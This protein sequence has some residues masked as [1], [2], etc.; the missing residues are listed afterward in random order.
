MGWSHGSW[1]KKHDRGLRSGRRARDGRKIGSRSRDSLVLSMTIE[2]YS[3]G[4]MKWQGWVC[5]EGL[6]PG[7]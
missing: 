2:F 1:N 6:V 3:S 5:G 4:F 7:W